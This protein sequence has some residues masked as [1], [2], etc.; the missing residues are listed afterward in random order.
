MLQ[1][2]TLIL[3]NAIVQF[4]YANVAHETL[5][6]LYSDKIHTVNIRVNSRLN[7]IIVFLNI[8]CDAVCVMF[9][10]LAWPVPS[11]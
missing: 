3:V 4:I 8:Q 6:Q 1:L 10:L 7:Y 2:I 9:L 11:C 5:K